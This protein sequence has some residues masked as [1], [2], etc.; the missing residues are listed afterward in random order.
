MFLMNA[1]PVVALQSK[2]EPFGPSGSFRFPG[3]FSESTEGVARAAVSTKVQMVI[4][5]LRSDGAT[6]GMSDEHATQRSHR[7]E[8]CCH[9]RLATNLAVPKEQPVFAACALAADFNP[10]KEEEAADVGPLV[11]DSDS[12]DS[13]DRDIEEAI[14]EYL[15]AKS[16]S[17]Q[18]VPSGSPPSGAADGVSRSKLEP[19]QSSSMTPLCPARPEAGG[20][21]G[22]CTGASDIRGPTSPVSVSSDDSFEQSIRAEIEQFLNEKKQQEIQKCDIPVDTKPDAGELSSRLSPRSSK[23]PALRVQHRQDRPG[24][25]KEFVFRKQKM[26]GVQPRGLKA[27]VTARPEASSNAR[28]AAPKPA[29][30]CRPPD[31]TQNKAGIRRSMGVGR[32]GKRAK[33]AALVPPTSDSSSDDG[34]EE[35]IQL[36]QLEKTRKEAAGDVLQ[37]AQLR[38]EKGPDPSANS[39][40]TSTNSA[41]PETHRKTPGKKKSAATKAPEVGLGT[42]DSGH[43]CRPLKETKASLLPGNAAA[44]SEHADRASCRADTPTE[45]MCAKAILDISKTILPVPTGTS[46]QPQHSSPLFSTPSMPSRSD[47]DSSSVDSDDSIEQEIRTFLALK[48]QT[49][50]LLAQAES[51]PPPA[52]SPRSSPGPNSQAGGPKALLSKTPDV[53]LSCRRKRRGGSSAKPSAPKKSKEAAKEGARDA[54]PG[55]V[56]DQPSPGKAGEA[57]PREA[58]DRSQPLPSKMARP[59]DEPAAPDTRGGASHDHSQVDEARGVAEKRSSDDKS[60]SLDSDEDLD[61]A[62]KDLL[63]SR[64][65]LKRRCR[66][67]RAAVC[68]KR[69]R[70][71]GTETPGLET[72]GSLQDGWRDRTGS[73]QDGW[74]DRMGSLQ[75]GWRDRGPCLL[76]GCLSKSPRDGRENAVRKTGTGF[77]GGERTRTD[78]AGDGHGP[79]AFQLRKKAP[80]GIL[81]SD[82]MEIHKNLCSAPSPVSPSDDSSSVDSDDSIEL[83][84]RKF[85]A[86]KAK[87]SVNCAAVHGSGPLALGAGG[88]PRPETLGRKEPALAPAPGVC[89]RSQRGRAASQLAEGLKSAERAAGVQSAARLFG[90][91]AK[92]LPAAPAK[93]ELAPPKSISGTFSAKGSPACRRNAYSSKDQNQRGAEPAA[94]ESAFGQLPSGADPSMEV[95]RASTFQ[96]SHQ[97][98]GLLTPSPRTERESRTLLSGR[99]QA[100]L[101]SPWSNFTQQS[102]LQSTWALHPDTAWKGGLRAERDSG[103]EGPAKCPLSLAVDPKKSL[104]FTGFAP[105]LSTQLFHFGKSVSWGGK[106]ASLFSSHLGVPLQGPSFS[107]FR[108]APLGP[109]PMLGSS[110]LLM[111]KEGGHWPS[112]K[113]PAG[114]RLPDRRTLRSEENILDMRY[115]RRLVDRDDEDQE[116]LGSDASEFSDSSMED[117]GGAVKGKALQL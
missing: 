99:P 21:P 30:A 113:S 40:S 73:L 77:S 24:T 29:T 98:C 57:A 5:T 49:G 97:S 109:S 91:G 38:E 94:A 37:R 75:D 33:S 71:S 84:I 63:R 14:Q 88:L 74:R 36:Y 95:E 72:L 92:G 108:E 1:P 39:T 46:G 100:D 51:S 65:K 89:T 85:L 42:L 70:S 107:A 79:L 19:S 44:K 96:V 53:P 45:L 110:H 47:G 41:L 83:E 101:A 22:S 115:R 103:T 78:S 90:Q 15:K 58:E 55:H 26:T 43:P 28:P 116:A 20:V 11:L 16:G 54:G 104:P 62:I 56:G 50:S 2:W 4:N 17:A 61:A 12:D 111:K 67:P 82:G 27:K 66:E 64:R 68:K 13:V 48:A 69:V 25:G 60:S 80:E 7:G 76:K 93:C 87:E 32:R 105:L 117:G 10:A 31:A 23:E 59:G 6:L 112:R 106:Q 8:R 3:C 18:P 35:A 81:F 86:E 52:W 114:L 9:D 102:R 34:I